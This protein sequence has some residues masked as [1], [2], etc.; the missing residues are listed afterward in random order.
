MKNQEGKLNLER[1][2]K[3]N[4]KVVK[5]RSVETFLDELL[6][7]PVT[8]YNPET[9][10]I[11]GSFYEEEIEAL[12]N[13]RGDS[14]VLNAFRKVGEFDFDDSEI[15]DAFKKDITTSLTEIAC[16]IKSEN[17][18]LDNQII[19]LEN[20]MVRIIWVKG[21][22]I[23]KEIQFGTERMYPTS[24]LYPLLLIT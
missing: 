19:F 10:E 9:G 18:N 21:R 16:K 17:R 23:A 5:S 13:A 20:G 22:S 11:S 3:E 12:Q 14:A 7:D 2:L 8:N 4:L 24:Y 6:A 1:L 15:I